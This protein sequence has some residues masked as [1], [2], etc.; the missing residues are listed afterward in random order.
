MNL[1]RVSCLFMTFFTISISKF[2]VNPNLFSKNHNFCREQHV[3][4]D[5]LEIALQIALGDSTIQVQRCVRLGKL[6]LLALPQ[7]MLR[8]L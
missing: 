1:L 4:L 6:L 8:L 2:A 7:M 3:L 5:S